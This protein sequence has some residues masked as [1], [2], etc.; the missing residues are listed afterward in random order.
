M[1]ASPHPMLCSAISAQALC[2]ARVEAAR[3]DNYRTRRDADLHA[4]LTR[5]QGVLLDAQDRL[6]GLLG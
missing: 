1:N 5:A 2:L 4:R 3:R 6:K